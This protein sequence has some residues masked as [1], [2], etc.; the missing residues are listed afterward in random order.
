MKL[1]KRMLAVV[2]A[3][4]MI[5]A[6]SAMAF[7]AEGTYAL[8]S[9]MDGETLVVSFSLKN[10]AGA[11]SDTVTITYDPAVL[12]IADPD[13]DIESGKDVVDLKNNVP[14]TVNLLIAAP[15]AE[16]AGE[17]IYGYAFSQALSAEYLKAARGKTVSI[18]PNDFEFLKITWLLRL[19]PV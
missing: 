14:E 12:K 3:V 4:A 5:F 9:E 2:M 1:A 18:D 7:A 19:L 15:N 10:G 17:I 13:L 11:T 8:T 6:L 16:K